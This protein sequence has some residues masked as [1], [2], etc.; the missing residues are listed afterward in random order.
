MQT[1]SQYWTFTVKQLEEASAVEFGFCI[2]CG[3][4]Q[5]SV[6]PAQKGLV[7]DS[8]GNPDVHG[9]EALVAMGRAR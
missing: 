2:A 4:D 8:C 3:Y 7:C 1:I 6:E 5:D 9:V